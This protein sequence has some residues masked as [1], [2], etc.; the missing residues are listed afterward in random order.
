MGFH[1][2]STDTKRQLVAATLTVIRTAGFASLSARSVANVADV[3]QALIFYHFGSMEGL[4]AQS[5]R[6]ATA[7]RVALWAPELDGV[8]DLE[9]LVD[10][11]RRLHK[12]EAAAGNV[13]VLAQALAAAQTDEKLAVVVGEALELW[14]EP[15]E[16][17][18]RR[19]L[20]GTVLEDVLSPADVSRTVAAAFVGVELFEGVVGRQDRDAFEVLEGMAALAAVALKAG[21][22]TKA[23]IRRRLRGT[24]RRGT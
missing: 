13:T 14:L 11:A 23:A 6:Q 19:V 15:L 22:V 16:A 4:V 9:S 12:K 18:A 1:V 20:R 17:A 2:T 3:N 5:C 21:P 8:E 24:R 7:E 10:V